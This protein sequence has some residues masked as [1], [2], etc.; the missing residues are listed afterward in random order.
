MD[1]SQFHLYTLHLILFRF[2]EDG[3]K[4]KPEPVRNAWPGPSDTNV[5]L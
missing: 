1:V 5:P 2:A 4:P 3:K